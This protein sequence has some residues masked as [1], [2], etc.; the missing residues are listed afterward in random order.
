MD[1]ESTEKIIIGF[2]PRT[3]EIAPKN[4]IANARVNVA[5]DKAKLAIV[6]LT[7]KD[8]V[9]WGIKGWTL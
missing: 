9:K 3:S 2:R 7:L 4:N 1:T 5:E 8:F 6:S